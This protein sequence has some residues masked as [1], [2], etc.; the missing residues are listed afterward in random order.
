MI[1]LNV[2]RWWSIKNCNLKIINIL[3]NIIAICI[4]LYIYY[5]FSLILQSNSYPISKANFMVIQSSSDQISHIKLYKMHAH[6]PSVKQ[7]SVSIIALT[8]NA[9]KHCEFVLQSCTIQLFCYS[10]SYL[11]T[12]TELK[13]AVDSCIQA[14]YNH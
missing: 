12:I 5:V 6:I 11:P 3:L 13:Y 14:V 8:C 7:S 10:F 4:K 1:A 2:F 9:K